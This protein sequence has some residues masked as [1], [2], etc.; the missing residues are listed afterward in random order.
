MSVIR[1]KLCL[2]RIVLLYEMQK[3]KTTLQE[4]LVES[5]KLKYYKRGTVMSVS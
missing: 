4:V 5:M 1:R 3:K 2:V